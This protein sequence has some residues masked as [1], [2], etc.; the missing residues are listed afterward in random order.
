MTP[1]L[2]PPLPPPPPS[3][4]LCTDQAPSPPTQSHLINEDFDL[5]YRF[6]GSILGK[7]L[8]ESQLVELPFAGFFLCKLAARGHGFVGTHHLA[9]FDPD[10]YR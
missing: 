8:Y 9:S 7:S 4:S 5:H 10:L 1:P 2:P 3:L 6:L